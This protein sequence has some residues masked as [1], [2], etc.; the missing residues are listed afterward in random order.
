MSNGN[1]WHNKRQ[2]RHA[3]DKSYDPPHGIIEDLITL[4]DKGMRRITEENSQYRK[5][6]D[7]VE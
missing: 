1:Y 3:Q 2:E 6:R 7:N 4:T 5:G